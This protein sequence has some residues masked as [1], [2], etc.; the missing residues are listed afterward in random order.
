MPR[1]HRPP[2]V[3]ATDF[4]T[5][6]NVRWPAGRLLKQPGGAV[7]PLPVHIGRRNRARAS[8]ASEHGFT[9]I[10]VM[11]SA[12]VVLLVSA[13]ALIALGGVT[14]SSWDNQVRSE[15]QALAQQNEDKLRGYNINEISNLNQ[16]LP[17][18]TLNGTIFT[19][20]ETASYITA[21]TG[22]PS[23]TNPS[24]DYLQTTSTVS[25]QNMDGAA[26]VVVTGQLTPTVGS[27]SA[28]NG[29][30]AV[31]ALNASG[32]GD[33]NVGVS[34]TGTS[35]ATGA[36]ASDGCA[37]F[38]DLP[39]GA[40]TVSV[41]PPVGVYVDGRTGQAV[42]AANP[43]VLPA[44]V[45]PG[46]T[47]ASR[48]FS[49][50][51]PGSITT[52]FTDAF[53]IAGLTAPATP[54][55]PDV[56][57][58]NTNMTGVQYRM[59]TVDDGATCPAVGNQ[60]TSFP[61]ADWTGT[62]GQVVASP[63]F[64]YTSPYTVYAGSCTNDDPNLVSSGAASDSSASVTEGGNASPSPAV[65]LPAMVVKLWSGTAAAPGSEQALPVAWH[66]A[67]TDTG[68]N[69]EYN[70]ANNSAATL[71][72]G[73]AALPLN[74]HYPSLGADD[75]GLLEY[76]G[77]PYG[78]YSVCVDNGSKKVVTTLPANTASSAS[79]LGGQVVNLY[80]GSVAS[81]GVAGTC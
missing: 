21:S 68:C 66:V 44:T 29:G 51:V 63:L 49:L 4:Q 34:L 59:C 48:A 1:A 58:F 79:Q 50:D 30:L 27:I 54:T 73:Q 61:A 23:C 13:A 80:A 39:S 9:L 72:A 46:T 43:D 75:T 41:T 62:G 8:V 19:I 15:A 11:A 42:T 57:A 47:P 71:P 60:D 78:A 70:T 65:V 7:D 12:L 24:A 55:A 53:P 2:T 32:G 35:T 17:P 14:R 38:G 37:L 40:Y 16:T 22:T 77:M 10:E 5:G 26:P 3:P 28:N 56:V 64:P 36:T 6:A 76:P 81:T 52:T 20:K 67:L 31:S 18:I 33:A 25:W 45:S 69:V 74:A